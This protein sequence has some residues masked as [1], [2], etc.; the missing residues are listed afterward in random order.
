M[1]WV[2]VGHGL[3]TVFRRPLCK[4]QVG[5]ILGGWAGWVKSGFAAGAGH[6]SHSEKEFQLSFSSKRAFQ[7]AGCLLFF[8]FYH[9]R[10]VASLMRHPAL[11]EFLDGLPSLKLG[12]NK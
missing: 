1:G 6:K 12:G 10:G 4:T 5:W 2:K 9:A 3:T 7:P 11:L 8:G